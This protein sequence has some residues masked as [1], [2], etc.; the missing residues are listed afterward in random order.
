MD[1]RPR[2]LGYVRV[3]TSEQADSGAGL[4]AQGAAI[5]AACAQRGWELV[6]V[7]AD[8]AASGSDLDRPGLQSVLERLAA[9]EATAL[10]VAKLDRATRSVVHFGGL[11]EWFAQIGAAFVACD[12]G[13]DTSTSNGRLIANIF[14]SVAEWERETISDRTREGLAAIR[15][16]GGQI[17]RPAV[18]DRPALAERIRAMRADGLTHQAIADALNAERVPTVR[19][20]A[21]WRPSSVQS[22]LGY[23]R[24]TRRTPAALLPSVDG[25]R[26]RHA[27]TSDAGRGVRP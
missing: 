26:R 19:G 10:V 18:V 5:R 23:R 12:L 4:D 20:A 2:V 24:P 22:A 17:G 25:R 13:I 9:G 14:A 21:L 15:A 27:S 8:E 16:R 7:V 1:K 11:M 6:D 3:S